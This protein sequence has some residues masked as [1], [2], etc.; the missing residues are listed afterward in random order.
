[1][2]Q[3]SIRERGAGLQVRYRFE[4][5]VRRPLPEVKAFFSEVSNLERVWPRDYALKVIEGPDRVVRGARYLVRGRLLGQPVLLP[6]TVLEEDETTSH[7]VLED[8]LGGKLEHFQRLEPG[9]GSTKVV[10]EFRLEINPLLAPA[11]KVVLERALEYRVEAIRALLEGGRFP[12]FRDPLRLSIAAGTALSV[13]AIA[14]AA[15]LTVWAFPR[16]VDYPAKLAA[17]FLLWFFTHDLAHLV[18]GALTGV[19]FSHYYVGLSNLYRSRLVPRQLKRFIV[20]LGIKIDRD[21]TRA[22]RFGYFAMFVAGPLASMIS[23]FLVPLHLLVAGRVGAFAFLLLAL[24]V[25]N[26][27]FTVPFSASVGCIAKGLRALRKD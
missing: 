17:W 24:S 27:A 23:P 9:D 20:A 13:L 1:L 25:A 16:P 15:F 3:K 26:A 19:R 11:A 21:K 2:H 5:E 10:E 8:V 12:E 6:F 22:G 4:Y 14:V 18:V 7:H